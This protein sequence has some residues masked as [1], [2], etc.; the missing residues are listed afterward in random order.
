MTL[1]FSTVGPHFV[2][3]VSDRL[4]TSGKTPVDHE[5]N[6]TVLLAG[7]DGIV[8]LSYTGPAY[9][10]GKPT[11]NRMAEGLTDGRV[12]EE[13]AA[14]FSHSIGA[15]DVGR[16][17]IRMAE[18]LEKYGHFVRG[19]GEVVGAGW[20]WGSA[21]RRLRPVLWHIQPIDH[22]ELGIRGNLL[23]RDPNGRQS[24]LHAGDNPFSRAELQ[25][26]TDQIATTSCDVAEEILVDAIRRA[27]ARKAA[28]GPNCLSV[29]IER[30]APLEAR[31]RFVPQPPATAV[32]NPEASEVGFTP[33]MIGPGTS[34]PPSII[35][36]SGQSLEMGAFR[37]L[38]EAPDS[39][40][41]GPLAM[42][43]PQLRPRI[44]GY[45][46]DPYTT[47]QPWEQPGNRTVRKPA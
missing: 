45:R 21:G 4:L 5:A 25:S 37:V 19:G 46:R 33:W 14:A 22:R 8:S 6:K 35:V 42:W 26:L 7:S 44:A 40:A 39:P 3:Q 28:V 13:R 36:G 9:L 2:L 43:S 32:M 16:S 24:L 38:L 12:L 11:D 41:G 30:T 31:I 47:P 29:R 23:P 34:F 1:I 10:H 18:H 20:Q 27:S 17:I 15:P